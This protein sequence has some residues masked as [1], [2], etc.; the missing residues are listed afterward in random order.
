M[1]CGERDYL[2]TYSWGP[3]F[4]KSN[5]WKT[6]NKNLENNY[7]F[8]KINIWKMNNEHQFYSHHYKQKEC[9]TKR[10]HSEATFTSRSKTRGH[11]SICSMD[12]GNWTKTWSR[13]ESLTRKLKY[14]YKTCHYES[15]RTSRASSFCFSYQ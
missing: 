1:T 8:R 15:L 9:S 6:R 4:K 11:L 12:Q 13:W 10:E 3:E 7:Y 2:R 14:I 5:I